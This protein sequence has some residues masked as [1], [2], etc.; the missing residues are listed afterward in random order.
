[1]SLCFRSHSK[2]P[3]RSILNNSLRNH[4]QA[5]ANSA[6]AEFTE[7]SLFSAQNEIYFR[8]IRRHYARLVETVLT[9]HI[10]P[11]LALSSGTHFPIAI[12]FVTILVI[13]SIEMNNT[14]MHMSF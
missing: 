1:M 11:I 4:Q 3:S 9:R 6:A 12:T 7:N 8:Y 5:S 2:E 10:G 14:K 13:T